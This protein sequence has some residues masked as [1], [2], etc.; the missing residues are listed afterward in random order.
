MG[1]EQCNEVL[2]C[3]GGWCDLGGVAGVAGTHAHSSSA[4]LCDVAGTHAHIPSG[5]VIFQAEDL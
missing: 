1:V 5:P 4:V 3:E 2:L